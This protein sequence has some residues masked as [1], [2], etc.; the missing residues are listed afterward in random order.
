MAPLPLSP[1]LLAAPLWLVAWARAAWASRHAAVVHLRIDARHPPPRPWQVRSLA[2]APEVRA[3]HVEVE[4]LGIGWATLTELRESFRAVRE[5]G[6]LVI[7]ELEHV[8]NLELYLAS[9]ADRVWMRPVGEVHATGLG[10]TLRFAGE[11][12]ARFGVRFDLEAAGAYKSFGETFTRRFAS[13]E[14]REAVAALVGDLQDE[15]ESAVAGGRG[16]DRARVRELILAAP[17]PAD[18]ALAAGLVDALG[19]GDEVRASIDALLGEDTPRLPFATWFRTTAWRD[20]LGAW[21][22]GAPRVVV[23]E[24]EGP[25]VDGDAPPGG[26][27]IAARPVTEALAQLRE[28][29]DVAA[30]VIEVQS[31]G[32]S[33]VA[34]DRIWRA[35][36]RLQSRKPVVA[37]FRDVA[38]SGGYYIAAGAAEII[39]SPTTLTGSIGVVGGKVVWAEGLGRLGVHTERVDGAPHAGMYLPDRPFDD[40]ERLRFR[41]SL[42]RFYRTFVERVAGGRRQPY[43]AVEA[44][45]RGRVWTGRR[46]L[47]HG[48]VDHLGGSDLA[49]RRA[50]QLAGVRHPARVDVR[51]VSRG[52]WL[53]RQVRKYLE[54]RV[55]LSGALD[56]PVLARLLLTCG[57]L[58]LVLWPYE[59]EVR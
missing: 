56:V 47:E 3:L 55:G 30:V 23:L 50:A 57:P 49:V 15:L 19:W 52:G 59:V 40:E 13:P 33:A 42:E 45:A 25:V 12:L 46:A 24:L 21:M 26:V 31:P 44:H 43:L 14:N 41:E 20:R 2:L 53:A 22:E 28:D 32:G 27:A 5:A 6:K 35:V 29:D 51:L 16:L 58:P 38:A 17:I 8:G 9:A 11:A 1:R 18:A 39:A 54:T 36:S 34:S 37:C 4:A 10:A 7:V 48:L